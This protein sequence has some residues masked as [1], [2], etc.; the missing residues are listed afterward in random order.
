M[1]RLIP[2]LLLLPIGCVP[3]LVI[4]LFD[5][6][7]VVSAFPEL[8]GKILRSE[9]FTPSPESEPEWTSDPGLALKE[10]QAIEIKVGGREGL[11]RTLQIGVDGTISF[12]QA[13]LIMAVGRTLGGL[14]EE[15]ERRLSRSIRDPRVTIRAPEER[16]VD[17]VGMLNYP[18]R[19][20]FQQRPF[21]RGAVLWAGGYS[22]L[23]NLGQIL[24]VSPS[25]GKVMVCDFLTGGGKGQDFVLEHKDVV[26]VTERYPADAVTHAREWRLVADF[27]A[28]RVTRDDL[29]EKI[30]D[31]PA[32]PWKLQK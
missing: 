21:I 18:R 2:A 4:P 6:A 8:T 23:A 22:K 31:L 17:I 29:V 10:G 7:P 20:T 1:F 12:P 9:E 32:P 27:F 26:I 16:H 11:T 19:N 3:V 25:H 24:V 30:R 5:G 15:L 28:G 14:R 13:G